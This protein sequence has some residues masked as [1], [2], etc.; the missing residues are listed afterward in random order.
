MSAEH[1]ILAA[2][3]ATAALYLGWLGWRALRGKSS[4]NCGCCDDKL[5]LP[6]K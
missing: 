6:R 3:L 2:I 4:C 5:K 1:L